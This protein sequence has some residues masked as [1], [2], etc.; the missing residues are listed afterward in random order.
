MLDPQDKITAWMQA[1]PTMMIGSDVTHPSPGSARGTPSIAAVVGSTD[2]MFGQFP[3]S[4]RLQESKKEVSRF[5]YGINTPSNKLALD[6]YRP[7][8]HDD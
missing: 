4:M 2:K 7:Q 3:A 1:Q 8:G 5:N 6:D